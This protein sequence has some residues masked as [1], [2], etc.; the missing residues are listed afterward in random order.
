MR[1]FVLGAGATGSVLAELLERQGHDVSCGDRDPERARHFL[2]KGSTIPITAVNARNMR[3]II[4]A[5]RGSHMLVNA[6]PAVFN[7][8]ILRAALHLRAHYLDMS[9]HL[10]RNPFKAEQLR[11]EKRFQQKNRAA[12]I[13]AGVA[14]G[15]TNLLVKRGA[16][17]FDEVNTVEVRLYENTESDDPVSQWSPEASF[18]EA[19]SRPRIYRN[20][21]FALA[22]RFGER[23]KFRFPQ[24]IGE[25]PVYLAAQDEVGT[26]PHFLKL[27]NMD[28]K[29][30][31]N[32]FEMLRRWY[33]QGK[34]S[35]ARGMRREHFPATLTPRQMRKL[36]KR[37]G[38]ANAHFAAVVLIR[39]TKDG[40]SLLLRTDAIFPS[41]FQLHRL[42]TA[43]SLIGWATA[44]MASLFVKHFPR[45]E[46][47]VF[48]PEALPADIRKAILKDVRARGIRIVSKVSRLKK[49]EDAED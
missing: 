11:F 10:T 12:V 13:L 38:L 15:L 48:A 31:G 25:V 49:D 26:L 42:G 5:A 23:E 33:R 24:P 35:K 43:N 21:R 46:A 45:D 7:E 1:I 32:E 4:R 6:S 22:P 40:E 41:L 2:G 28:V 30:G 20:G 14:P 37:G 16:E 29:I 47:G 34:L 27:R 9:A 3:A 36:V 18:D 19:T 8:I 39:G 44:Q 17:Q